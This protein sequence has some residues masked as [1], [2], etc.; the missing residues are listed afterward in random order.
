[1]SSVQCYICD[2]CSAH[3][4]LAVICFA[5]LHKPVTNDGKMAEKDANQ[6]TADVCCHIVYC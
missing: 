5:G 2:V 6:T 4:Y 3:W 1:M